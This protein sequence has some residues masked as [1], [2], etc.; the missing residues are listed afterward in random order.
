MADKDPNLPQSADPELQANLVRLLR[1]QGPLGELN[2][3]DVIIPT[4]TM[5][6]V[7]PLDVQVRQPRFRSTD[8]FSVGFLQGA[9]IDT[10][11]ADTG[12]LAAGDYD[13]QL[14]ISPNS[15]TDS[16]WRVEHRNAANN[17][18]LAQWGTTSPINASQNLQQTLAYELGDNERLRILN[19]TT[20]PPG[21]FT[22]A[23]IF[24]RR[25]T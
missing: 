23:W 15:S 8:V 2:V 25:R 11:H 1:V 19:G 4:V 22:T 24:A 14:Y 3:L 21:A 16:I 6:Q 10:I 9:A 17:A 18:T 7:V 20:I 5:G 12:Q 13:I